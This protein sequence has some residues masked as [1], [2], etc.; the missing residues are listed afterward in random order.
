[1]ISIILPVYNEEPILEKTLRRLNE[2]KGPYEVIVADG[3]SQ[4]G[5][6]AI[7]RRYARTLSTPKGRAIQMNRAAQEAKGETLLFLHADSWLEG[8]ALEAI[9]KTMQTQRV[10][11]GCLTQK[12]ESSHPFYRFLEA[13]GSLRAKLLHLFYG[14]QGI[15]VRK[16][17]FDKLGG[18]PPLP[19]LEDLGF[20]QRLRREGRTVILPKRVFTSARR[21]EKKG[22]LRT[23]L[24]N[25]AI[26][27]LYGFGAKPQKLARFYSDVR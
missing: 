27:L 12:I 25:L 18:Y 13:S 21:W 22:K 9:E 6:V 5:G 10:I 17:I 20:S 26:I 16:E 15:F 2:Q 4:D 11:G 14:D 1:M 24:C 23:S 7:A 19:L 3:G 8:G